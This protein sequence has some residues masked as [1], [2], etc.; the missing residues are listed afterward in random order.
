MHPAVYQYKVA[1]ESNA[2][3]QPIINVP[4]HIQQIAQARLTIV[5]YV[6][7]LTSTV[8]LMKAI[9]KL[10]MMLQSNDVPIAIIS[11]FNTFKKQPKRNTIYLWLKDY[12]A[13]GKA[14]LTPKWHGSTRQEYGW[15]HVALE[16]YHRPQKP[17]LRKVARDLREQHGFSSASYHNVWYFFESLPESLKDKSP[18]RMGRKQY[19][20]GVREHIKRSTEALPVGFLY[21]G[22]GHCVDEYVKH[23]KTGHIVRIELT[24]WMDI[25]SRFIPGW[26]V[27]FAESAISTMASLSHAMGTWDH[28]PPMI[29]IDHGSGFKA[30]LMNDETSGFYANFGITPMFAIPGNAKAKNIERFFRTLE[31]DFG[32]D[33][34]TYCGYDMSKDTSRHFD[35]KKLAKLEAAGKIK[36]PSVDEWMEQFALW[37]DRYH[38]RPHPEY[39][40]TTPQAM[41]AELDRIPVVDR[42]MLVKPREKVKVVKSL[43]RLHNRHYRNEYLYQLEGRELIAEYDLHDDETIRVFDL[44]GRLI[45]VCELKSKADYLSHSRME[46]ALRNSLKQKNKRLQN[47]MDENTLRAEPDGTLH[48]KQA[49]DIKALDDELTTLEEAK[50]PANDNALNLDDVANQMMLD[51]HNVIDEADEFDHIDFYQQH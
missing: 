36:V 35:N 44:D 31:D 41:W 27:S 7:E 12:K 26:Y 42:N 43:I 47:K 25:K 13:K 6:I 4:E 3:A 19:N 10:L 21:Q 8:P 29:H 33:W 48:V 1:L 20:D 37:L 11:A 28:V 22:D 32:K 50:A 15:E 38:A 2:I 34:A 30:R 51:E 49:Q 9:D 14:A 24:A 40:N 46:D 45:C 16:L 18:W 5:E 17:A 39:P 23:P